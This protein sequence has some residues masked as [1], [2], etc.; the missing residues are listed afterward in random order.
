MLD[1]ALFQ[2]YDIVVDIVLGP[3]ESSSLNSFSLE[4]LF[5][6]NEMDS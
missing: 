5:F 6:L 1:L 4:A 3:F 2:R